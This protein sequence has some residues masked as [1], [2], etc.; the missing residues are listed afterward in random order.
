MFSIPFLESLINVN[1]L[2]KGLISFLIVTIYFFPGRSD[3]YSVVIP[4]CEMRIPDFSVAVF[5]GLKQHVCTV[6]K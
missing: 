6:H 3:E 1:G 5:I 4:V 2:F